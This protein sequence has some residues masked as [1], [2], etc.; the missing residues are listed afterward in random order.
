MRQAKETLERV[1]RE[2]PFR[3]S[4][5]GYRLYYI[6]MFSSLGTII[7]GCF[8]ALESAMLIVPI[9]LPFALVGYLYGY[10]QNRKEYRAFL[11][12]AS[13]EVW[14]SRRDRKNQWQAAVL[15]DAFMGRLE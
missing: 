6:A 2:M 9:A 10:M 7:V 15:R 11:D 4:L 3:R 5:W 8:D 14:H 13:P 1:R 12:A